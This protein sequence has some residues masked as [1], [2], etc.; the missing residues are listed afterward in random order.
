MSTSAGPL[1][2]DTVGQPSGPQES[3]GWKTDGDGIGNPGNDVSP[4]SQFS[5]RGYIM[6]I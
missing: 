6:D 1:P 5:S 2:E 4:L 3:W